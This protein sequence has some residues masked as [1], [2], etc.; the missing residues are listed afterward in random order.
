MSG[1]NDA[2]S[3]K[4]SI[5]GGIAR[6]VHGCSDLNNVWI[7]RC[8]VPGMNEAGLNDAVFKSRRYRYDIARIE[9]CCTGSNSARVQKVFGVSR[10]LI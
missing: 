6:V 10:G 4:L 1:L 3:K 8:G 7:E 9:Q 5:P 2:V